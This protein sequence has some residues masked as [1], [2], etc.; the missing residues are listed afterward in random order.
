MLN[1]RSLNT[2]AYLIKDFVKSKSIDIM[3]ISETW[4]ANNLNVLKSA[5]YNAQIR[6]R[7]TNNYGG[8][9]IFSSNSVKIVPRSDLEVPDLE[10]TWAETRVGCDQFV[11][12]SIYIPPNKIED[13]EHLDSVLNKLGPNTKL[14]LTGDL[15][16]RHKLW[17]Q[18]HPPTKRCYGVAWRMGNRLLELCD[19]HNLTILNNGCVTRE[20][21]NQLS[22]PDLTLSRG[23]ENVNWNIESTIRLN[24]DHIP[25]TITI[26]ETKSDPTTKWNL[27]DTNWSDWKAQ[28][29]TAFTSFSKD[30]K[31]LGASETCDLLTGKI[32]DAAES[33]IPKKQ[34]C[35]HSR[36]FMNSDLKTLLQKAKE[37]RKT[38]RNRSDPHNYTIY[39]DAVSR[40]IEAYNEARENNF[41]DMCAS[42]DPRDPH[43]WT[44]IN[45][46]IKGNIKQIVQPLRDKNGIIQ[47]EDDKIS[48]VLTDSHIRK[49]TNEDEY[50]AQWKNHVDLCTHQFIT[51]EKNHLVNSDTSEHNSDITRSEVAWAI[52]KIKLHSAPGPDKV[53]PIMV[54]YAGDHLYSAIH[55]KNAG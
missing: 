29:N 31:S 48:D 7:Q 46:Q 41:K 45:M 51:A 39:T 38:Y 47:F 44:K 24:S 3:T 18:W 26:C 27:K 40:F 12:G 34:V 54:K 9:A 5:G 6:Q 21:N 10:A 15:N 37:A 35:C 1:A 19:K 20:M 23:I 16:C 2:S 43:V 33:I 50:D 14:L 32:M 11:L 36:S 22:S 13:L 52:S 4:L 55:S 53:L 8:V 49:N 25:I 42:L 28:T 17:E 30:S